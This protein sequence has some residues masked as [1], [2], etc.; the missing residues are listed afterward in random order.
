M[1]QFRCKQLK[2]TV[3]LGFKSLANLALAVDF[4]VRP[5]FVWG[6]NLLHRPAD[7][8]VLDM[9]ELMPLVPG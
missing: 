2:S 9:T 6:C 8:P 5:F 1:S 7:F 4:I 3:V